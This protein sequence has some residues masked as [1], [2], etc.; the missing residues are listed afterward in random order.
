ME[1]FNLSNQSA[2]VTMNSSKKH[3]EFMRDKEISKGLVLNGIPTP[4]GNNRTNQ[5]ARE[6]VEIEEPYFYAPMVDSA[7]LGK[8]HK[9]D[10][11]S[12]TIQ[13]A[14]GGAPSAYPFSQVL[15]ATGVAPTKRNNL[16]RHQSSSTSEQRGGGTYANLTT[17]TTCAGAAVGGSS[18]SVATI[19][20]A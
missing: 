10:Y 3:K 14:P 2:G 15:T 16:I 1:S 17:Q 4:N 9:G 19:Q 6:Q 12:D 8:L 13:F 20:N 7:V 18:T 11:I 5:I